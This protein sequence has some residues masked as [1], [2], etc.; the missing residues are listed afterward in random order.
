MKKEADNNYP[1]EWT[2]LGEKTSLETM[3]EP[4]LGIWWEKALWEP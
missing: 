4:W 2:L 1:S 3:G